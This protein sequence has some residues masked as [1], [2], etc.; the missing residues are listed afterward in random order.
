MYIPSQEERYRLQ[1]KHEKQILRL[2]EIIMAT[3]QQF[4]VDAKQ[5]VE[6]N[7]ALLAA[8]VALKGAVPVGTVLTAEDQAAVDAADSLVVS[9]VVANQAELAV[10]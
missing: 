9:S 5:L 3:V 2:E 10:K 1:L 7:Q 6:T 4:T 8:F